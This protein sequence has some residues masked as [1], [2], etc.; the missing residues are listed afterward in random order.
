MGEL[1]DDGGESV[2]LDMFEPWRVSV[3]RG[4]GWCR[5]VLVNGALLTAII[6]SI[7]SLARSRDDLRGE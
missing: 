7:L 4:L 3:L 6:W 2:W 1:G 5:G